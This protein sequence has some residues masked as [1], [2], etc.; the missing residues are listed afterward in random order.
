[1][2]APWRAPVRSAAH[3]KR[4]ELR[5]RGSHPRRLPGGSQSALL[6]PQNLARAPARDDIPPRRLLVLPVRIIRPGGSVPIRSPSVSKGLHAFSPLDGSGPRLRPGTS[7]DSMGSEWGAVPLRIGPTTGQIT[8][9]H[10]VR[11]EQAPKATVRHRRSARADKRRSTET[12]ARRSK[13][14]AGRARHTA[15][16]PGTSWRGPLG[17]DG[18]PDERSEGERTGPEHP[19]NP[20]GGP[21]TDARAGCRRRARP[22]VE[23]ARPPAM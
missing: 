2:Q 15:P 19:V 12:P 20:R 23:D 22:G 14:R 10:L 11:R 8:A 5:C 3:R 6:T 16:N 4:P 9:I 1:V 21:R 17:G 7:E 18:R 13:T